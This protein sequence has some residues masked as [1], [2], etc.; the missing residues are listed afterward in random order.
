ME[1][2]YARR[3]HGTVYFLNQL[4]SDLDRWEALPDQ[5]NF[6]SENKDTLSLNFYLFSVS[7]SY[8]NIIYIVSHPSIVT[9]P[10]FSYRHCSYFVSSVLDQLTDKVKIPSE[11]LKGSGADCGKSC[12]VCGFATPQNNLPHATISASKSSNTFAKNRQ[13]GFIIKFSLVSHC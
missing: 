2:Y 4:S 13:E 8:N 3:F 10:N 11:K 6:R 12:A 7:Y 9:E 1:R 5:V